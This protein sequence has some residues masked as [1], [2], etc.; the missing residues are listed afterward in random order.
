M[1]NDRRK[2]LALLI[3]SAEA[4]KAALEAIK[5]EEQNA[6]DN[7][8]EG[9]QQGEKGQASE[10]S[11]SQMDDAITEIESAIDKINNSMS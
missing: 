8:P 4:L 6:L 9:F 3:E 5:D 1:N 11:I 10:A 7:M 2:A